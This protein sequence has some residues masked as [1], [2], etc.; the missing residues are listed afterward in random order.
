MTLH[1]TRYADLLQQKLDQHGSH[2]Y[3]VNSGW[4]GG[5]FGTGS[6]MSIATTRACIDA[7]LNGSIH[8]A[9]FTEDPIF[10][11]QTP[12]SLPGI[13]DATVLNPRATWE[14]ESAYEAQATKLARM[15]QDNFSQYRGKGS[16][17]YEQYGPQL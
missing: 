12:V 17:D 4:S 13:E 8:D 5:A 15:F 11:L 14:D 16:V 2:A 6:R 10:G 7:I 9:E 1:P 3:L